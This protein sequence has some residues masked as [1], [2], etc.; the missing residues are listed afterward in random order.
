MPRPRFFT[1]FRVGED[2][3]YVPYPVAKRT[4]DKLVA[5]ALLAL[6]APVVLVLLASMAVDMLVARRDRGGFLYGEERI[7]RGRAF[8][9]LKFRTLRTAALAEMRR[10]GRHAR[11]YEANPANLT[12]AGR[13]VLKPWYLDE[14]PQFLNVLR[15]EISLVGPRPWPASMVERQVAAGHDYRNHVMAGLT[16]PAQVT[17][18]TGVPF[19]DLDH[20]Y[21]ERCRSLGGWALVRYDVG[22]LLETVRVIARGEGLN[23]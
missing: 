22:I 5:A 9:L 13:R 4:V 7:S 15:G 8:E 2:P 11:L 17:K 12:W 21:V 1:R 23:Y 20:Q 18:G 10:S 16:G 6:F 19:A 3:L 14:I